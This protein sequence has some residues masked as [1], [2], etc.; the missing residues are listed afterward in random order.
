MSVKIGVSFSGGRITEWF[1]APNSF[2]GGRT[3]WSGELFPPDD[4]EALK[5]I[6]EVKS[7][8]DH[9]RHA[10][11]V[12]AAWIFKGRASMFANPTPPVDMNKDSEKFIF[13]RGTGDAMP[14]YSVRVDD[15][16]VFEMRH[17]GEGDAIEGAFAL[18][19]DGNQARWSRLPKL[20]ATKP[21]DAASYAAFSYA[22]L[23]KP[24]VA[25]DKV[26][27]ELRAAMVEELDRAGL[28]PEEAKAMVATWQGH[29]FREPGT[30]VLAIVPRKHVDAV[31]PLNITP[32]PQK[33]E[34]VFVV[35]FETLAPA[36]EAAL[37]ALLNQDFTVKPD[38]SQVAAF[39]NLH[40]GRFGNGALTRAQSLESSRLMSRFWELKRS[41][42]APEGSTTASR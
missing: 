42:L 13:Y 36:K 8:G 10:R 4:S 12:S 5:R 37:L 9:Y 17:L 24:A 26:E 14:P 41:A 15:K 27:A 22:A 3:V 38:A 1:P 28:T 29:W 11:E 33:V 30:R 19:V 25:L 39:G 21:G 34:R 40:L 18:S 6:P 31:L 23:E 7:R 35:R 20:P 2:D 32:K 16:G